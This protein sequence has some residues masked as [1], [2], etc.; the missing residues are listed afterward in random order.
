MMLGRSG[1]II[2]AFVSSST[3]ERSDDHIQAVGSWIDPRATLTHAGTAN[4]R[5]GSPVRTQSGPKP[6]HN[7]LA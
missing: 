5:T 7:W 1:A 2:L 6:D 3:A 4:C